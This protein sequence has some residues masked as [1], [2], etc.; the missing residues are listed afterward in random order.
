MRM[1]GIADPP[2]CTIIEASREKG[3][4]LINSTFYGTDGM[5]LQYSGKGV[6]LQNNL[7]EYNDWSV[8]IMRQKSGGFGTVI[9]NGEDDKFIRNTLRF[10]GASNGFRPSRRNPLVKLNHIHHQCWG[11]LQH[12]G[13]GVQFQIGA[14]VNAMAEQ[15]WVHSSPKYGLRFDGQPPRVGHHGT[16]KEN[17]VWKCGGMMVK[18]DYHKV[19]NNLAFE[20]RNGKSGDH[21]G[22]G[23]ALC[24]LKFV[25]SNPV[26]I[27]QHSEV[28]K[29][30]ADVANGGK[31]KK[32]RGTYPL[33]GQ[34][35]KF[36]VVGKVRPEVV[37]ADNLD[38]RPREGSAYIKD[39]V[40]PYLYDPNSK[41][42]WIPGRQLYKTSTPVPPN[43]STTVKVKEVQ[44][45]YLKPHT[46]EPV[47]SGPVLSGHP[48]LSGQLSKSRKLFPLIT[49]ILTSIKR[50]PL[51]RWLTTVFPRLSSA[52][53]DSL[54]HVSICRA[55]KNDASNL[56]K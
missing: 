19:I 7:F 31:R 32:P 40:G 27:N 14:Q 8:A 54:P 51:L 39:Q 38:F 9:S 36:N 25:R 47:L 3:F 46:V 35:V 23:C 15:N 56:K 53:Y 43:G 29:N 20:K 5:A 42:Y 41:Y 44:N 52:R 16:M 49:V 22:D 48:L 6:V 30:A 37:D 24:V 11:M 50:S 12:D 28:L 17:V 21:Q 26:E 1:L 13:A 45:S 55:C 10:N 2:R 34:S 4:Q 18:G 33:A